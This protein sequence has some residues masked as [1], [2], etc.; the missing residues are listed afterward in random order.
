MTVLS[1]PAETQMFV[2]LALWPSAKDV[3]AAWWLDSVRSGSEISLDDK[4][5]RFGRDQTW[6]FE[7]SDPLSRWDCVAARVET[8]C[9]CAAGVETCLPVHT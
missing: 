1:S 9:R 3:T 2:V 5:K 7:S 8:F 4:D 6:I